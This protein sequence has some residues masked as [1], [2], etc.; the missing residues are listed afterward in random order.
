MKTQ[1]NC[2]DHKI[3]GEFNDIPF[4][5]EFT[6]HVSQ[7]NREGNIFVKFIVDGVECKSKPAHNFLL[8]ELI[9]TDLWTNLFVDY[10][11]LKS[12]TVY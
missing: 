2:I 4:R 9:K 7:P 3:V 5:I 1:V 8:Q 6:K 10:P 11:Y 12:F